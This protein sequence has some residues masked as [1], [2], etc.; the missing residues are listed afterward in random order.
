M[1]GELHVDERGLEAERTM[2]VHRHVAD[3]PLQRGVERDQRRVLLD[4]AVGQIDTHRVGAEHHQVLGHRFALQ[5]AEQVRQQEHRRQHQLDDVVFLVD[6]QH[7][8]R[9]L[10][11]CPVD[12]RHHLLL[13]GELRLLPAPLTVAVRLARRRGR[14]LGA[15]LQADRLGQLHRVV[16]RRRSSR[17]SRR[18]PRRRSGPPRPSNGTSGGYSVISPVART[19]TH[20]PGAEHH[21]VLGQRFARQDVEE[22]SPRTPFRRQGQ[23]GT[24]GQHGGQVRGRLDQRAAAQRAMQTPTRHDAT[25]RRPPRHARS[26]RRTAAPA[27]TPSPEA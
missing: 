21:Q 16:E 13:D 10:H 4:L 15:V 24:I 12:Q 14:Q 19:T 1:G 27:A 23:T 6:R 11:P 2:V 22:A 25:A 9:R 5:D 18:T 20:R 17:R 8:P 26:G 7:R 3:D